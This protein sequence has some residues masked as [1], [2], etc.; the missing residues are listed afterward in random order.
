MQ[1]RCCSLV[2]EKKPRRGRPMKAKLMM[3]CTAMA[4]VL[5]SPAFAA[6][7]VPLLAGKVVSPTGEA[8]AGIPI[9]ARRDNSPMTVAVYTDA[10]GEYA[11][12]A[13]SELKPGSYS[14]AVDLPDFERVAKPVA[15]A[16]GK[17]VTIDFTLKAKPLAYEDAT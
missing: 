1:G 5:L 17:A 11:F 12:P 15:L 13:W 4:A 8:L 3:A 9:K 10:K 7:G 14:I 2:A 16:N 6:D